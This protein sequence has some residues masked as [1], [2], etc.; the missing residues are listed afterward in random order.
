MRAPW[1]SLD[2][3]IT[4]IS[5]LRARGLLTHSLLQGKVVL[6]QVVSK[7]RESVPVDGVT[8]SNV[9][10]AGLESFISDES[11]AEAKDVA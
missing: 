4:M 7:S 1:D 8:E 6:H 11:H 3:T 10:D 9:A 5:F 2:K